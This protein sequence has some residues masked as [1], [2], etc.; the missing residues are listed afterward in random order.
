M[1]K[2][3]ALLCLLSISFILNAEEV[4]KVYVGKLLKLERHRIELDQ[5]ES[6]IHIGFVGDSEALRD[7]DNI[8]V[9]DEVLAIFGTAPN[10]QGT[11]RVNKLLSIHACAIKDA[12]CA[13]VRERQDA[14]RN[15]RLKEIAVENEKRAELAAEIETQTNTMIGNIT[16][17]L[18]NDGELALKTL[19][20]SGCFNSDAIGVSG[21][22]PNEALAF[23]T[24]MRENS[25]T[26]AFLHLSSSKN[27]VAQLYGLSGL[28]LLDKS[29]YDTRA[30]AILENGGEVCTFLGCIGSRKSVANVIGTGDANRWEISSGVWP[31]ALAGTRSR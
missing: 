27:L 18:S 9:G 24:L 4:G 22:T 7:L 23:R 19:A 3:V 2:I 16:P 15:E 12:E 31:N 10:T 14:E 8:K 1:I 25:A 21:K 20:S 5:A 30:K 29:A 13:V 6:I 28:F 17:P 26:Q 11:G